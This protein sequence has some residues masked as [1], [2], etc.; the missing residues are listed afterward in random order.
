M[1]GFRAALRRAARSP[2]F[3]CLLGALAAA[4]LLRNYALDDAYIT[5]RYADNVLHGLGFTYNPGQPVLTTTA[6]FF[7]LILVPA[8][9]LL[10]GVPR[11]GGLLSALGLWAAAYFL[12]RWCQ[13]EGDRAAG[14]I[15]AA[16]LLACPLLLSSWGMETCFWLGLVLSGSYYLVGHS[17][18]G[19]GDRGQEGRTRATGADHGVCPLSTV[20]YALCTSLLGALLLALAV[21]TRAD[22]ALPALLSAVLACWRQRR[23]VWREGLVFAAVALP[24]FGWLTLRFGSPLPQSLQAKTAQFALGWYGYLPGMLVWWREFVPWPWLFWAWAALLPVGLAAVAARQRWALFALLWAAGHSVVYTLMRVAGYHWYY[25][26]VALAFMLLAA[27]GASLALQGVR[28]ARQLSAEALASGA[29]A[30]L[31]GAAAP[32]VLVALLALPELASDA[33]LVLQQP[34][35][36]AQL[37]AGAG[38]WVD[39][40]ADAGAT[41]GVM[42]MGLVGYYSRRPVVDFAG[43]SEPAVARALLRADLAWALLHYLPEYLVLTNIN[44]LYSY[45]LLAQ[46]WFPWAYRP[47]AHFDDGRF[48]GSPVTVYRRRDLL[49]PHTPFTGEVGANFGNRLLLE[50]Y[51]MDVNDPVAGSYPR[52]RLFWRRLSVEQPPVKVFAHVIDGRFAIFGGRDEEIRPDLWPMNEVVEGVLLVP[53]DAATRPGEYAVEVGLYDPASLKRLPVMGPDGRPTTAEVAILRKIT[54]RPAG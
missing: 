1:I 50:R 3:L 15:G 27:L 48:F 36:K 28:R 6:P 12:C 29:L 42:E 54:V 40:H 30:A 52:V 20:H 18:Q 2:A 43:L 9:L 21:I 19:T 25:A 10:G 39:A 17:G 34:E 32:A 49:S 24:F 46:D 11:A 33:T 38:R 53:V 23:L 35:A 7:A 16:L 4:V 22:A 14:A 37:Y 13:R 45:H 8:S 44:P 51:A 26:P 41:V 5:Y 47:V 31:R